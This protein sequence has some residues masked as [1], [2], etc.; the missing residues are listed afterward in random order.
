MKRRYVPM[1]ARAR[2]SVPR[3]A[4]GRA[5]LVR[6]V[7]ILDEG[8]YTESSEIEDWADAQTEA[9]ALPVVAGRDRR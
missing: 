7:P 4:S 9:D 6:F 2:R 8:L 3:I 1:Q 5:A